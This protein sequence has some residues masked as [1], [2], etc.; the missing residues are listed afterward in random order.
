MR[1]SDNTEPGFKRYA[2]SVLTGSLAGFALC[3]VLLL[4][5]S[6]LILAGVL[7]EGISGILLI[8]VVLVGSLFG[9]AFAARKVKSRTMLI[10]LFAGVILFLL[11]CAA[12]LIFYDRFMPS[13]SGLS[14]I[15]AS[16]AGGTL[17]GRMAPVGKGSFNSHRTKRK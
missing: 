7:D 6:A 13:E 15:L 3:L 4:P 17:G 8:I 9:G 5:I 16:A 14:L 10:G 11:L 12:G 2:L 1:K